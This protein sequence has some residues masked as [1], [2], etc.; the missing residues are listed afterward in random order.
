[1]TDNHKHV[2][3]HCERDDTQVPLLNF[4]YKGKRFSICSEHL[5]VLLHRPQDLIGKLPDA[6]NLN[7]VDHD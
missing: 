1:M 5:P 4:N 3:I 7:P 2:C 6:E